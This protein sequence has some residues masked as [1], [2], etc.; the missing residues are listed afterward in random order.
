[1]RA[2]ASVALGS[3]RPFVATVTKVRFGPKAANL[4]CYRQH[5]Q[6]RQFLPFEGPKS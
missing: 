4:I 5:R 2:A 1:M 3:N 6:Y